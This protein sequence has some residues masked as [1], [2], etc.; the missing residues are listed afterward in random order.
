MH[1]T[2]LKKYGFGMLIEWANKW[3]V[4]Y[5]WCGMAVFGSIVWYKLSVVVYSNKFPEL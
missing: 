5:D 4:H 3:E 1:G 2:T